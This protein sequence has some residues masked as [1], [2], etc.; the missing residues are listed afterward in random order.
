VKALVLVS[1][2]WEFRGLTVQKALRQ[3]GLRTG[4]AVLMLYGNEDKK[5]TADVT[6]IYDLLEKHHPRAESAG[7]DELHDLMEVGEANN[8]QGTQLIKDKAA[9]N[10]IIEFLTKFVVEE[11]FEWSKRRPD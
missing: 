3:P 6:R 9:E 1:P 4:V 2:A 7:P 11:N 5:V 8:V 10:R